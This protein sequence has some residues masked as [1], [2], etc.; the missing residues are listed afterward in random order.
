MKHDAVLL[1]KST[2][3]A[4][5]FDVEFRRIYPHYQSLKR[6]LPIADYWALIGFLL[7]DDFCVAEDCVIDGQREIWLLRMDDKQPSAPAPPPITHNNSW[8]RNVGDYEEWLMRRIQQR[9]DARWFMRMYS[10]NAA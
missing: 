3:Y 10:V 6:C 1:V 2:R 4:T 8:K 5:S 7:E 9:D